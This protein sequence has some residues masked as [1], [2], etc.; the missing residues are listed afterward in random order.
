MNARP[1][2]G[3]NQRGFALFELVAVVLILGILTAIAV[4]SYLFTRETAEEVTAKTNIRS[5]APAIEA[6]RQDNRGSALDVDGD[7]TTSGYQGMTLALLQANYASGLTGVAVPAAG[8]LLTPGDFCISST[9]G[10][11]TFFKR[12]PDGPITKVTG[13]TLLCS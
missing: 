13:G 5:A 12:G 6:W 8:F 1:L 9:V 3:R 4:S 2:S 10:P 11:Y 7:A